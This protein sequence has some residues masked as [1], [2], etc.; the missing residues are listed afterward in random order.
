M[1]QVVEHKHKAL[2]SS[3]LSMPLPQKQSQKKKVFYE[4][5]QTAKLKF[6]VNTHVSV[7]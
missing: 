1:V 5:F 3:I 6:I 7:T 2:M 4:K